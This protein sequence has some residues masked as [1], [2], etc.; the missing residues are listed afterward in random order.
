M[1]IR[2]SSSNSLLQNSKHECRICNERD[3]ILIPKSIG[4]KR[5]YETDASAQTQ[6]ANKRQDKDTTDETFERRWNTLN[7]ARAGWNLHELS[8]DFPC[9]QICFAALLHGQKDEYF[10]FACILGRRLRDISPEIDRVLLCGP[11]CCD[12]LAHRTTLREVGWNRLLAVDTISAPHLDKTKTKRHELVFT[13]LRAFEL[14]YRQVLLLDLDIFPRNCA[15]LKQLFK[16]EAPAG[17]Y[18]CGS[19]YGPEP[20]HG[21]LISYDLQHW[22]CWSPNAGVLRLDPHRTLIQRLSQVQSLIEDIMQRDCATYLPEQYYLAERLQHWRHID[23]HWNWEVW[24]EWDDPCNLHPLFEA[25]NE[26]RW[27]GWKGYYLGS[28]PNNPPDATEVLNSVNVWHFSGI[29]DTE[30]W[31]FQDLPDAN[32]VYESAKI[33]FSSRDP[34]GIVARALYEWRSMLDIMLQEV[35]T[36]SP[37][38]V[39]TI[40][41]GA[42]ATE[43]R[44]WAW[45]CDDCHMSRARLRQLT[46]VPDITYLCGRSWNGQLWLCADCIVARLRANEKVAVSKALHS[47]TNKRKQ[48]SSREFRN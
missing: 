30:P 48:K 13:K 25:C 6:H 27:H 11:G 15:D 35:E 18:Q 47:E 44:K 9:S 37:L 19:Y 24:S 26:A 7:E 4:M 21:T 2:D 22:G 38:R 31:M 34:G 12:D 46:N 5:N 41:L 36:S 23:K 29:G 39:S 32:A 17:K 14:P 43:E 33:I 45:M 3:D 40:N 8:P 28:R 1:C 10:V 16:I 20:E 42:R